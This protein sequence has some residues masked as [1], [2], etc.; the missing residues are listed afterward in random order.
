M[1]FDFPYLPTLSGSERS[2]RKNGKRGCEI[3]TFPLSSL[4]RRG[5]LCPI[6]SDERCVQK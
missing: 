2:C 4:H 6:S 5:D 3:Q 1:S